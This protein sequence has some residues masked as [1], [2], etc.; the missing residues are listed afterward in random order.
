MLSKILNT[1]SVSIL[2][3]PQHFQLIFDNSNVNKRQTK[4]CRSVDRYLFI[5]NLQSYKIFLPHPSKRNHFVIESC[6]SYP[7]LNTSKTWS[8]VEF[9][10]A[11]IF[12]TKIKTMLLKQP[13]VLLINCQKNI[14]YIMCLNTSPQINEYWLNIMSI[15]A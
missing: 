2:Q 6:S 8:N 11:I 4:N 5:Y 7:L 13:A 3:F 1:R 10:G 14:A 9:F 12:A 15:W